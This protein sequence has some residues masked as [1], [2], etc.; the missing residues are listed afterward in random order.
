VTTRQRLPNRRSHQ[1]TVVEHNGFKLIVGIGRYDD[2][3]LAEL[4]VDTH[5]TGTAIDTLL[6]DSAVLL[7]LALQHGASTDTV[8]RALSRTGPLAA[9]LDHLGDGPS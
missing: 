8:R 4:F 7:S 6:K 5:K 1:I 9:V 2:G 3:Q